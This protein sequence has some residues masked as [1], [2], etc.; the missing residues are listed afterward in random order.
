MKVNSKK[1]KL[2]YA[3][4]CL[5]FIIFVIFTFFIF[6]YQK[7][8]LNREFETLVA[9]N[10]ETYTRGQRNQILNLIQD[11]Q[12]IQETIASVITKT[13][14]TMDKKAV[15]TVLKD[16]TVKND[17][18]YSVDYFFLKE[19]M[20]H[21]LDKKLDGLQWQDYVWLMGGDPV[22]SNIY[23]MDKSD[24]YYFDLLQPIMVENRTIGALRF[25]VDAEN[26]TSAFPENPLFPKISTC[27]I[28][29]KGD[30]SYAQN[31]KYLSGGNLFDVLLNQGIEHEAVQKLAKVVDK[32][33]RTTYKV[34]NGKEEE[35]LSME[36]LGYGNYR[37]VNFLSSKDVLMKSDQILHGIIYSGFALI[38]LT[39]CLGCI[40]F[41]VLMHQK[42]RLDLELRRYAAL[43]NFS[44]TILMQYD[45]ATDIM[46]LTSNASKKFDL[47]SLKRKG[48][49][50]DQY[51]FEVLHPEDGESL[52]KIFTEFPKKENMDENHRTKLRMKSYTGE[53]CWFECQYK[54][55][56]SNSGCPRMVV[57][58]LTDI[59]AQLDREELLK[60]QAQRDVLTGAYNKAG[61][62][63]IK[64]LLLESTKGS[65]FMLDLDN[66][67]YINDT[68]GHSAGDKILSVTAEVL[69]DIF[70]SN[71]IVARIG[72]DEFV[73]FAPHLVQEEQIR[74]K[75]FYILTTLR[76]MKLD[77]TP[78]YRISVS[79]GVAIAPRDGITYRELYAAAD[80]AMYSVKQDVKGSFSFY[81]EFESANII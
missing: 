65:F 4:V 45:Y 50:T 47:C 53:Y 17:K 63:M 41:I 60:E 52:Q 27:I 34:K 8:Q 61:E 21:I 72:G 19:V 79:I 2:V 36:D 43:A 59:T 14:L 51:Q 23:Q 69:R 73:I 10:L 58:K 81:E 66:F 78:E 9:E 37:I 11:T 80:K 38:L 40:I 67:K 6:K 42:E 16:L 76:N 35:F 29:G 74:E 68:Y 39:S 56:M 25:R 46:E 75:I 77:E 70:R 55:I 32:R 7:Q 33:E 15:K 3:V 54:Y 64:E 5:S 22:I 44:D 12:T 18:I 31:K 1:R 62:R 30:V 49:T 26:I 24:R 48:I 13:E 20:E 28:N 71:D 57:G